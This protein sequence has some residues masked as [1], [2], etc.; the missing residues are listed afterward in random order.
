MT[1]ELTR[2]MHDW[3]QLLF[4]PSSLLC[5]GVTKMWNHYRGR[6]W[7]T[8]LETGLAPIG[9]GLILAGV[10]AIFRVAGAGL[11]SWVIA[12]F[13]AAILAWRAQLNPLILLAGGAVAFAL[14]HGIFPTS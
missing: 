11:L 7:H 9:A 4:V 12:G 13:V 2:I 14:G 10:F 6:H 5:Y 8:A 3:R 1:P